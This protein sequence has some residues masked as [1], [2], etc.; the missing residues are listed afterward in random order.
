MLLNAA[1]MLKNSLRLKD[2]GFLDWVIIGCIRVQFCWMYFTMMVNINR[3]VAL[4]LPHLFEDP[5][6]I[7]AKEFEQHFIRMSAF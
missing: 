4:C 1:A 3:E 6:E 7:S 2:V 5:Q